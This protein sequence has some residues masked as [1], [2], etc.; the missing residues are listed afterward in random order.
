MG[1]AYNSGIQILVSQRLCGKGWG[2]SESRSKGIS[3]FSS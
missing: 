2:E 1:K 3:S